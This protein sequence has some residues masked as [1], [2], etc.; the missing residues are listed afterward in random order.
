MINPRHA[1]IAG[2]YVFPALAVAVFLAVIGGGFAAAVGTVSAT[3]LIIAGALTH[4]RMVKR[5][6]KLPVGT[7]MP[8]QMDFRREVMRDAREL[9][10]FVL[11]PPPPPIR[12]QV[13]RAAFS[14]SELA[15]DVRSMRE[16]V[17]QIA[18]DL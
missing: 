12:P 14:S 5:Q 10:A 1:I 7:A 8:E 13:Q 16:M 11:F 18:E 9:T 6:S 17:G 15:S 4:H 2:L 3:L